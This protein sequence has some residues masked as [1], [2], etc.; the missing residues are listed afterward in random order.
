MPDP[1][2]CLS[3]ISDIRSRISDLRSQI[4]DPKTAKKEKGGKN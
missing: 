3:P 1:D 2:F 4:P